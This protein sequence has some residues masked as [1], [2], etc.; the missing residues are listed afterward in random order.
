MTGMGCLA[1][2]SAAFLGTH[3][4]LSHPLRAPLV[5][6]MGE[7][8]FRGLYSLLAIV[9]FGL[10]IWAYGRIG[11]QQLLWIAGDTSL[12]IATVLMWL[13]AILFVGSFFGNPALPGARRPNGPPSG[14]LA[15]TR[16]PMMWGFAL[17]AIVHI[18]VVATPKALIFDG[19]ILF[20]AL[21]GAV[22]QDR[23]KRALMG[24]DWHDWSAQ[25]A[26]LPFTRGFA[27]PGTFSLIGGTLLFLL[28]TWLHPIPV[29]P[30][31]FAA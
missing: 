21:V 13:G 2:A 29:G 27:Y 18:I 23:K 26:F 28:A 24:Q 11:D 25:T 19:S 9:T 5:S 10:M 31:A 22:M 20:L 30:W 17:W 14:A 16:H 12:L 15:I 6:R 1:L 7:G 8:P 4:L 3:F